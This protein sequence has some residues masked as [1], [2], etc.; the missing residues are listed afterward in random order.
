MV[1]NRD[2]EIM[3][4]ATMRMHRHV[5]INASLF[6]RGLAVRGFAVKEYDLAVIGGGPGG[7]YSLA[8]NVD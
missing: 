1:I 8:W 2:L 5:P 3:L 4:A 6:A 7:K